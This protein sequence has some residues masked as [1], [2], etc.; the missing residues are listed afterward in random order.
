[1]AKNLRFDLVAAIVAAAAAAEMYSDVGCLSWERVLHPSENQ[2]QDVEQVLHRRHQ[3]EQAHP[4]ELQ[5]VL[6]AEQ[7]LHPSEHQQSVPGAPTDEPFVSAPSAPSP[8]GVARASHLA[9]AGNA[10]PSEGTKHPCTKTSTI[11]HPKPPPDAVP[12]AAAANA[13]AAQ[14]SEQSDV[15][16]AS[17]V[18]GSP[19]KRTRAASP[20]MP[21]STEVL[22]QVQAAENVGA[23]VAGAATRSEETVVSDSTTGHTSGSGMFSFLRWRGE[24]APQQVY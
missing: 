4:S 8:I 17:D 23:P 11:R 12:M 9:A 24:A 15:T 19:S 22:V 2:F 20:Q 21:P 6:D 10:A 3:L 14:E 5:Q 1:M 13:G 7:W 16:V 18:S